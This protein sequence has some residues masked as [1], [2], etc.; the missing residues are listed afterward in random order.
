M[1]ETMTTLRTLVAAS[2][3]SSLPLGA[4]FAQ[5]DQ[6]GT[7]GGPL[8]AEKAP[9]TTVVGQTKPPS[10]N[11]SPTSV[12]PIERLTPRQA[13]DDAITT[14][15]CTGCRGEPSTTGSLPTPSTPVSSPERRDVQLDELRT[16]T[17]PKK[18]SDLD[19]VALAS[20]HRE[21]AK[22][23]EEKTNGL[24]Q[25][26]LVSVCDGCG[27]QKPAK[28]LKVEDWPNRN[29]PM[30]TGSVDQKAPSV[31][32]H[33]SEA[34]RAEVHHHGSLEADLSPENVDAIRRMPQQ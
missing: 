11:A 5:A 2:I 16:A 20:A 23:A 34:K 6:T 15:V 8:S 27:D 21:Q 31:K 14:R 29:V 25:S 17:E 28:A 12:K 32:A 13:A 22:S 24:W 19:T 26:W 7:G 1:E 30:T 4:V 3:L 18:Q 9:N 10:R 33:H